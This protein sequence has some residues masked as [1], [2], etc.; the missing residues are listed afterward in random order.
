MKN[1]EKAKELS[2]KFSWSCH[3]ENDCRLEVRLAS[4]EMAEWKDKQFEYA[5]RKAF[6]CTSCPGYGEKESNCLDCEANRYLNEIRKH[7]SNYSE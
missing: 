2:E 5:L 1:E 7:M 6:M 3:G 4:N